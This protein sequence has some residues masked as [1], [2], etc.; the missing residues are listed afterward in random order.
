MELV[1]EESARVRVQFTTKHDELRVTD[2]SIAV[3]ATLGRRGLSEI[4]NHLLELP[5]G[6]VPLDFVH[7]DTNKSLRS[8]LDKFLQ[9][10]GI[11][12]E[13]V[14]VLEYLPAL[15]EPEVACEQKK[16]DWIASID[17]RGKGA[18]NNNA[19]VGIVGSFDGALEVIELVKGQIETLARVERAHA[20]AVKD[21][22][23]CITPN[24][25]TPTELFVSASQDGSLRVW[26][27]NREDDTARLSNI[28][29]CNGHS[30]SVEALAVTSHTDGGFLMA[31]GG[32]DKTVTLW[33]L[34][35]SSDGNPASESGRSSK[36]TKG[37]E[38]AV[39][40][41]V[42]EHHPL[43]VF[44]GHT[45][46]VSCVS[47]DHRN[48]V[49]FSG[50]WD[51]T[52]RAWDPEQQVSTATWTCNKVVTS[53]CSQPGAQLMATGHP[54]NCVRLWDARAGGD[55]SVQ[56]KLDGHSGWVTDVAW[57]PTRDE[58][59]LSASVD[60]TVCV[61]DVRSKVP[62]YTMSGHDGKVLAVDWTTFGDDFVSGGEDCKLVQY[63]IPSVSL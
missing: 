28:G 43:G 25:S 44:Q 48:K 27:L 56:A 60:K 37:A 42:T 36:K 50:S 47:W 20:G 3:P 1:E 9:S 35:G 55:S 57:C 11:S 5:G 51:H 45:D 15:Q 16:P 46:N 63:T 40:D 52:V 29:I 21:V 6:H 13:T 61:W 22:A 53:L 59:F 7:V 34:N 32:W 2:T 18:T 24:S 49:L 58:L 19:S 12:T 33:E 31:S 30:K 4:V 54:D 41:G 8:P 39:V 23:S 10:E 38:G 14:V 26:R 62:L 17:L